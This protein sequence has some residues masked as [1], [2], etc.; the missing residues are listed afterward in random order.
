M[1]PGGLLCGIVFNRQT[2]V[3]GFYRVLL[4]LSFTDNISF[5]ILELRIFYQPCIYSLFKL[6]FELYG[7]GVRLSYPFALLFKPYSLSFIE[8]LSLRTNQ[9]D[10][11]FTDRSFP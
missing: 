6:K 7:Y 10:I 8:R 3:P 11:G 2:V 9:K 4:R 5:F 1:Q